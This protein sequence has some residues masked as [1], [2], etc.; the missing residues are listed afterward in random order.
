[1]KAEAVFRDVTPFELS[2]SAGLFVKGLG[3]LA[4]NDAYATREVWERFRKDHYHGPRVV[5][6]REVNLTLMGIANQIDGAY[7][8]PGR[9]KD[10]SLESYVQWLYG[11][12]GRVRE[13]AHESGLE[14]NELWSYK[15]EGGR[16]QPVR[17]GTSSDIQ[18]W[19]TTSLAVQ[20]VISGLPQR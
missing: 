6:G 13:S 8:A 17:Y 15:I 2:Y 10:P 5:W 16:L 19:N 9:L 4:S 11:A 14:H 3:P 12:M 18:L 7:A 20:F 1:V